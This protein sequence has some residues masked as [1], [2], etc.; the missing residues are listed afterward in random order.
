M[1]RWMEELIGGLRAG[2]APEV[3]GSQAAVDVSLS[4]ALLNR[5]IVERLPTDGPVRDARLRLVAGEALVTLRLARPRFL[6]PVT[7][8]LTVER[9]PNLP[10]S[11]EFGLRLGLPAG[12]GMLAGIG[13]N[14][15]ATLPPG[16]RLD[17]DRLSVDLAR[18]LAE[19]D[20][21]WVLRYARA[22]VVTFEPGRVRIQGS[23]AVE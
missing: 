19:Q 15:F 18:L 4:E 5:A 22:L 13:A 16:M 17:G 12:L 7:V 10:G 1:D 20:L 9:Q 2:R 6:P 23:A 21:G 14:L 11:S 3:A 8:T